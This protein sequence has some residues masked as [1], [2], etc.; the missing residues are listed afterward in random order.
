MAAVRP[1]ARSER[2]CSD[3][4]ARHAPAKLDLLGF[5]GS[6]E[7][8]IDS[9]LDAAGWQAARRL[10]PERRALLTEILERV[11]R[12]APGLHGRV[13]WLVDNLS[14][15]LRSAAPAAPRTTEARH[16]EPSTRLDV[17][18]VLRDL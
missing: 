2:R 14:F 13:G 9:L 8:R 11:G 7:S 17:L 3:V 18:R 12:L 15:D 1:G 5:P 10:D 6:Y 16:A 4:L